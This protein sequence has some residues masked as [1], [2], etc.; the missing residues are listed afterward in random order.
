[1]WK[2]WK[3]LP[4][5]IDLFGRN[6]IWNPMEIENLINAADRRVPSAGK[7]DDDGSRRPVG[8]NIF[9]GEKR[10]SCFEKGRVVNETPQENASIG[11]SQT[12]KGTWRMQ[13]L[14]K[15]FYYAESEVG[16]YWVPWTTRARQAVLLTTIAMKKSPKVWKRQRIRHMEPQDDFAWLWNNSWRY[17]YIGVWK[18]APPAT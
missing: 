4:G 3:S 12:T 17:L 15:S 11:I 1:M 5:K 13:H 2:R 14:W 16:T 8:P 7:R 18:I 6:A 9:D 10:A